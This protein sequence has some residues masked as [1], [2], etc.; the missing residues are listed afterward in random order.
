M[1]SYW[2]KQLIFQT[3]ISVG[4]W[5]PKTLGSV[6]EGSWTLLFPLCLF[7]LL[8]IDYG[9]FTT[10]R[11]RTNS[12]PCLLMR[13]CSSLHH[14]ARWLLSRSSLL[15]SHVSTLSSFLHSGPLPPFCLGTPPLTPSNPSLLSPCTS[16]RWPSVPAPVLFHPL[17]Q[18]SWTPS[19]TITA[20]PSLPL[21]FKH[22]SL[23]AI[24]PTNK[25]YGLNPF[26][27]CVFTGLG[28]GIDLALFV[29]PITRFLSHLL[30]LCFLLVASLMAHH[31]HCFSFFIYLLYTLFFHLP[32]SFPLNLWIMHCVS[33]CVFVS[34]FSN[35]LFSS[36]TPLHPLPPLSSS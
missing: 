8:W 25:F 17:P 29:S 28:A 7:S 36:D 33:L 2:L 14:C 18:L 34:L 19:H 30:L 4:L 22:I 16:L 15:S 21:S 24:H 35:P 10:Q 3:N 31:I 13:L 12:H 11:K 1:H 27:H 20:S 26:S 23:G 6:I 9:G 5:C 32:I